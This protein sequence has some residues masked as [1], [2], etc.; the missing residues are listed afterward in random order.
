MPLGVI[1]RVS[2]GFWGDFGEKSQERKTREIWAKRAP[3]P[4]H[5]EPTP[6]CSPMSQRG[7]PS[8]QQDQGA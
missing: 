6:R 3:T 1:S 2:F 8:P 5:R 4:Q 7:M